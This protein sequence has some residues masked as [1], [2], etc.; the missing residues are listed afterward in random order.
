[1]FRSGRAGLPIYLRVAQAALFALFVSDAYCYTVLDTF[2]GRFLS[3]Q[4]RAQGGVSLAYSMFGMA[5][6][7]TTV[8]VLAL[9]ALPYLRSLTSRS[10]FQ[11]IFW[12]AAIYLV[13]CL[14][15]AVHPRSYYVL[16]V[17]RAL[18]GVMCAVY[19]AYSL[20]L[21]VQCFPAEYH[22]QAI[23]CI[24]SGLTVGDGLSLVLGGV[25]Y[26]NLGIGSTF[27]SQV[28]MVALALMPL[29][30]VAIAYKKAEHM[31]Q[32][33]VPLVPSWTTDDITDAFTHN[34]ILAAVHR[35]GR[36]CEGP[37]GDCWIAIVQEG[38]L[39]KDNSPL[40]PCQA[41]IQTMAKEADNSLSPQ[42]STVLLE[43][44]L[45]KFVC[46]ECSIVGY[47]QGLRSV[48]GVMLPLAMI[49]TPTWQVA[50]IFSGE[51]VGCFVGPFA[52]D[53]I[54]AKWPH[55]SSRALLLQAAV[56]TSLGSGLML[57][58]KSI[59][60][61]VICVIIFGFGRGCV[62]TLVCLHISRYDAQCQRVGDT[63]PRT[64][65]LMSLFAIYYTLGYTGGIYVGLVPRI[66][67][68]QGQQIT[69]GIL[70]LGFVVLN[71]LPLAA[72][73]VQ[74]KKHKV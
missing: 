31:P 47:A 3:S 14:L 32:K 72:E 66:G 39:P 30:G 52:S 17:A 34:D 28:V 57:V 44:L 63:S 4:G 33:V 60:I 56:L 46:M 68:L 64:C 74:G 26:D 27:I 59:P 41:V 36:E 6:L 55:I 43:L 16:L 15:T 8:V 62:E 51:V 49:S 35:Y 45:D 61:S 24:T 67:D 7:V 2:L 38:P 5:D 71:L 10:Q 54:L 37:D 1:M 11:I 70:A 65:A 53:L 58:W 12:S 29:V 9:Q 48:I 42:R 20:T 73:R 22:S 40:A 13:S 69:A 19:F 18:Q 25:L 50:L 21:V 23:A